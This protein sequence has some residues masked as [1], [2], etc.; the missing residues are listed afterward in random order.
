MSQNASDEELALRCAAGDRQ[1]Y[2]E[3]VCRYTPRLYHF[4][5][6]KI[7]SDQDVEDMVQETF[8]KTFRN[9]DRYNPEWRFST[10]IYTAAGRLAI[11]HY[12]RRRPASVTRECRTLEQG[13]EERIIAKQERRNIWKAARQLSRKQYQTL[14]LR[15]TEDMPI[16]EIAQVLR[17]TPVQVRV[18]LHRARLNLAALYQKRTG[19][20]EETKH[21]V[22]LV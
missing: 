14:W 6:P 19:I 10:W 17:M 20:E 11:S 1:A 2:E 15:Y 21:A 7:G 13:P 3:L 9:I 18:H 16:K 8:L 22:H 4:L 12:R 5:L